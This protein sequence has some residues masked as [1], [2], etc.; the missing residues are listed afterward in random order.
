MRCLIERVDITVDTR[1]QPVDVGIRWAGGFESR[2]ELRRPVCSYEQLDDFGPL[3]T[4]LGELRRAGW[5]SPRIADQLN[6]EGF[7]TPKQRGAFTADVVRML[8]PR[9]ASS[10]RG[11]SGTG[12]EPPLWTADALA[13]RLDI[14]VKKLKDWV[15]CGWVQAIERPFGD[16]WILHA[17]EQELKQFERRAALSQ[18]GRH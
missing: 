2:H 4:R 11:P 12:P 1:E 16:V 3:M 5:R 17:D 15:R 6:K 9:V 8:F 14:S 13:R 18:R 7:S 10:S